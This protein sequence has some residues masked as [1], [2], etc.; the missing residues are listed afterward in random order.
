MRLPG[1]S[2]AKKVKV[3]HTVAPQTPAKAD[4]TVARQTPGTPAKWQVAPK[5]PAARLS[6]RCARVSLCVCVCVR[7]RRVPLRSNVLA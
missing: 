5:T 3:D 6:V 1:V 2:E 7:A 4:H